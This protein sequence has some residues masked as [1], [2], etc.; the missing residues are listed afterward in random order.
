M[1]KVVNGKKVSG[2]DQEMPQSHTVDKPR[3]RE[4]KSQDTSSHN[5]PGSQLSK[6]TRSLFLVKTIT[7]L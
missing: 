2:Y 4:E 7:K 3:H 6:A 5:T 1:S